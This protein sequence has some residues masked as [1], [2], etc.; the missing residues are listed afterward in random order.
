VDKYGN[1]PLH[2]ACSEGKPDVLS[3]LMLYGADPNVRQKK[4]GQ[5]ALHLAVE[6]CNMDCIQCLLENAT[7]DPEARCYEGKTAL[8]RAC[9]LNLSHAAELLCQR[10]RVDTADSAGNTPLYYAVEQDSIEIVI[11]LLKFG[12]SVNVR[13][14]KGQNV[15]E[16][17]SATLQQLMTEEVN[18]SPSG[19][20]PSSST[21][22]P[23]GNGRRKSNEHSSNHAGVEDPFSLLDSFPEPPPPGQ[24][25]GPS[26]KITSHQNISHSPTPTPSQNDSS[27][28]VR[29]MLSSSLVPLDPSTELDSV[30]GQSHEPSPL[31]PQIIVDMQAHTNNNVD[32]LD[33]ESFLA[34]PM[35][36]PVPAEPTP[37]SAQGAAMEGPALG[38][39]VDV[40]GMKGAASPLLL[41]TPMEQQ[42]PLSSAN[43]TPYVPYAR[44]PMG[45]GSASNIPSNNTNKHTSS[46][47]NGGIPD[48][49][50]AEKNGAVGTG[51]SIHA[52]RGQE[53]ENGNEIAKAKAKET[54]D[55]LPTPVDETVAAAPGS[56]VEVLASED[57]LTDFILHSAAPEV[58]HHQ[59]LSP[60]PLDLL[61]NTTDVKRDSSQEVEQL[62]R[63]LAEMQAK[64]DAE[65]ALREM[66]ERE[67][68]AERL[69]RQMVEGR[70]GSS[71]QAT[72]TGSQ[73]WLIQFQ[74]IRLGQ[75]LGQGSFGAVYRGNWR[76]SDVAVKR[77]NFDE[78][79]PQFARMVDDFKAEV[80][81]LS[82]LRH[83]NIILYMGAC[84][85]HPN[86]CIVTEYVQCGNLWE[87]L[88]R[89]SRPIPEDAK[90]RITV[91]M[92]KGLTYLHQMK[93]PM[94]HR[95]LKS[96]NILLDSQYNAKLCDFGLARFKNDMLNSSGTT[97]LCGTYGYMAPE[98]M[99]MKQY[100]AASDMY[101]Y[102]T[103]VWEMYTRL[104]P[105]GT[106]DPNTI[107]QMVRQ[108]Y[109]PGNIPQNAPPIVL[110]II[111]QCW[112]NNAGVRP[113]AEYV[114]NWMASQH[115]P[116]NRNLM[117]QIP[118]PMGILRKLAP[119]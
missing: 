28:I 69:K 19:V 105:F 50:A 76:G 35:Q 41:P 16:M 10:C 97:D 36:K 67:S 27:Y 57:L 58:S 7:V 46:S 29:N 114:V 11:L 61:S 74:E 45:I 37:G 80:E 24:L 44:P 12:A 31:S 117:G 30:F 49:L 91:D 63:R 40:H 102:G 13:N 99:S 26:P 79:H 116:A 90:W 93:P 77:V 4:D 78:K 14:K 115:M 92:A 66:A 9:E 54:V 47:N 103:V 8:H 89:S 56:Q 104:Q 88:H 73:D 55:W 43:Y 21:S 25:S 87:V 38:Y 64:L 106:S 94:L 107:T 17:A 71:L 72:N 42:R 119:P 60:Q 68:E 70:L 32:I 108:G 113:T 75:L 98:V 3:L 86:L 118:T 20:P 96:P 15:M 62:E 39:D 59:S 2:Y 33:L 100:S 84:L 48:F 65:S 101:A 112:Q 83:P 85:E 109:V 6:S 110:Q 81:V 34:S 23:P 1:T 18:G 82:R 51:S 52:D 111:Q 53:R 95:D 22:P 5:S